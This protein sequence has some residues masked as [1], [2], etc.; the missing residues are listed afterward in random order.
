MDN[1]S[2]YVSFSRLRDYYVEVDLEHTGKF[3]L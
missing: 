2:W 1:D 3:G